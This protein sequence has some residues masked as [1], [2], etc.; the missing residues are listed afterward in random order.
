M[1]TTIQA[2][3][4]G[5]LSDEMKTY[6]SMALLQRALPALVHGQFGQNR[7]LPARGGK[8]IEFRKFGSL[9]AATTALTE[10]VTPDGQDLS[11]SKITATIAQYGGYVEGSDLLDLTAIDPILTETAQLL[12]EQAG[13]SMD[14]IVRDV[15]AAGTNV[16]YAAG[17]AS[18][19]T[20]A[21][22]D[23]L[24]VAEIRKAVRTMK[25][26]KVRPLADGSYVAIVE[27]G[28]TYDLQSDSAWKS[29]S[30][31]AG[32]TQIFSGE[33]GRL[34]GVRFVETTE[35]ASFADAGAA[36]IDV[37]ATLVIGADAYGIIPLSGQSL[38]FMFK[39]TGSAGSADPL[40]QRWTSGWKVAFTAKILNDLNILRIEH[41]QSA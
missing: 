19:V 40:D 39:P 38:E 22:G 5:A 9:G 31:Y 25:R 6:Y 34:Y 28:T 36:G 2:T 33:I 13:L 14:R 4:T 17:R 30:E 29:A 23:N 24:T 3:T 26:N 1:A 27:P 16:Q 32:S 10:G 21:A 18:R 11:V 41:A 12:G 37:F 8:T 20:V 15:L 7:P 35:A